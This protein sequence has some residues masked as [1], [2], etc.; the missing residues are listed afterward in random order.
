V[1]NINYSFIIP[2]KNTPKLLE[3]CI[4][5]I[6]QRED[7][8]III[9]D[10]NSDP[11]LV[12]F[13]NFPG[14][15]R[16]NTEIILT[17]EGKGAGFARN[18]GLSK[19]IGKF[20]LFAD[21]DDYYNY[22]ISDIFNDYIN[23]KSDII[24]FQNNSVDSNIYTTTFRCLNSNNLI[25]AWLIAKKKNDNILKFGRLVVWSKIFRKEFLL[26][27]Q[28]LFDEVPIS[29]DTTFGYLSGFYAKSITADYRALYCSTIRQGSIRH[30]KKNIENEITIFFVECKRYKFY[31]N[32]KIKYQNNLTLLKYLLNLNKYYKIRIKNILIDLDFKI[33]EI[34]FLC[35]LE[36]IKFP[37]YF[38]ITLFSLISKIN[39]KIFLFG[40]IRNYIHYLLNKNN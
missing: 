18:I 15:N 19:A 21:A 24:F 34:L 6:P 14:L 29:N 4:A 32:N 33:L 3:R 30:S 31:K 28:I 5:S 17:K 7:T 37:F 20:I 22:C 27:N 13:I 9:I 11:S 2:H 25:R 12:D 8:Q 36:I 16:L 1:N 39:V 10:D 23:S 40:S 35:L 38:L 26:C